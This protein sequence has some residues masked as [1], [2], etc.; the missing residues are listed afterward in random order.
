MPEQASARFALVS[1]QDPF[2]V[3][4]RPDRWLWGAVPAAALGF[5]VAV[6]PASRFETTLAPRVEAALKSVYG[7]SVTSGRPLTPDPAPA[8]SARGASWANV[9]VSGRDVAVSG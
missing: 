8:G 5:A 3:R 9:A 6:H 1:R 2:I 4:A 7:T